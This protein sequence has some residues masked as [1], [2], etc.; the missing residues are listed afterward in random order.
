VR[1]PSSL[2]GGRAGERAVGFCHGGEGLPQAALERLR[3]LQGELQLD[4][5]VH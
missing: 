4:L 2:V 5:G 1:S 3:S